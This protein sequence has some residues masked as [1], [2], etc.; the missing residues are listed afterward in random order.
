MVKKDNIV[1]TKKVSTEKP[2][3]DKEAIIL[4]QPI[5]EVNPLVIKE[6]SDLLKDKSLSVSDKIK[7]FEKMLKNSM[8]IVDSRYIHKALEAFEKRE[9]AKL[10]KNPP[11]IV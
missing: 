9:K 2:T 6:V 4:L 3:L 1:K 10:L 7:K 8:P 11:K 5:P